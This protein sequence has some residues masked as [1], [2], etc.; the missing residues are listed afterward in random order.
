VSIVIG[1]TETKVNSDESITDLSDAE[2]APEADKLSV[3]S[4][5]EVVVIQGLMLKLTFSTCYKY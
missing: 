2:L 3:G 1:S 5:E 4:S